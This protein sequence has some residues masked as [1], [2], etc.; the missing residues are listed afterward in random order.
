MF[1]RVRISPIARAVSDAYLIHLG[2]TGYL[3][4][5]E[6]QDRTDGHYHP[7]KRFDHDD[8]SSTPSSFSLNDY[9]N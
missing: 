3:K 4:N 1:V 6:K 7:F 2:E 9:E 8:A 5:Q